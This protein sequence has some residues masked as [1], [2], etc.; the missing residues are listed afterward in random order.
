MGSVRE[1]I[2]GI[3]MAA[4]LEAEAAEHDMILE[5]RKND[6]DRHIFDTGK[7]DWPIFK[8]KSTQILSLVCKRI[9]GVENP[10][11]NNVHLAAGVYDG[12]YRD[13]FEKARQ[14]ILDVIKE[15]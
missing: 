11:S 4:H 6:P 8:D 10:Y 5:E 12:L 9:E 3:L 7:I 14:A 15:E 13:A 1:D 2:D